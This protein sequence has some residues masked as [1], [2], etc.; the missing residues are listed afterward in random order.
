[1]KTLVI[2]FIAF[3]MILVIGV[4]INNEITSKVLNKTILDYQKNEHAS[5]FLMFKYGYNMEHINMLY[6]KS[7]SISEFTDQWEQDS[8]FIQTYLLK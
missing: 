6:S 4:S 8:I 7:N 5:R 3:L 2:S 1:M